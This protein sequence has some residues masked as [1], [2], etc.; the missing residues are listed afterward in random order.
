[1]GLPIT[2]PSPA[3][4]TP[5][6]VRSHRLVRRGGGIIFPPI[7]LSLVLRLTPLL[8]FLVLVGLLSFGLTP[9]KTHLL[10]IE[11]GLQEGR[12]VAGLLLHIKFIVALVLT[13]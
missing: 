13:P 12:Q 3:T 1:M 5:H 8:I 6:K 7:L 11:T 4:A 2:S 10:E 9:R